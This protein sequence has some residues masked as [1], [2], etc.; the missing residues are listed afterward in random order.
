MGNDNLATHLLND[1]DRAYVI[2]DEI[3]RYPKQDDNA[4]AYFYKLAAQAYARQSHKRQKTITGLSM[5]VF[6]LCLIIVLIMVH[7]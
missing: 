6:L 2:A 5:A 3:M 7:K 4:A 1:P